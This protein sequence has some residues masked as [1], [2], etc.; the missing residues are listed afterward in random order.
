MTD[1]PSYDAA[2]PRP[3]ALQYQWPRKT[4]YP[5][6][7]ERE[8]MF[9]LL[10][11]H[12]TVSCLLFDSNNRKV[13]EAVSLIH[14]NEFYWYSGKFT[15]LQPVLR[16]P[17]FYADGFFSRDVKRYSL[18]DL[19]DFYVFYVWTSPWF[20]IAPTFQLQCFLF[21]VIKNRFSILIKKK[22]SCDSRI[23]QIRVSRIFSSWLTIHFRATFVLIYNL[24]YIIQV[25]SCTVLCIIYHTRKYNLSH[26]RSFFLCLF[27][28]IFVNDYACSQCSHSSCCMQYLLF[29]L[30]FVI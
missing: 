16:P 27:Y 13:A 1:P 23:R 14:L 28:T 2:Y 9:R 30:N 29:V 5:F 19:Y 15:T 17:P 20:K 25:Y 7:E 24:I 8:V 10:P 12:Q 11:H 18:C 6:G 21:P 3:V 4:S 22:F 26:K